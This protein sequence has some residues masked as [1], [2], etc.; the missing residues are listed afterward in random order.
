MGDADY[1]KHNDRT[2]NSSTYHKKDGTKVRAILKREA[3][4]E[5][6]AAII[7]FEDELATVKGQ[8]ELFRSAY[9][10]GDDLREVAEELWPEG[11]D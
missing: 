11:D 2:L 4:Q 9:E 5:I 8:L 10:Y 7:S 3:E 6:R 1:R